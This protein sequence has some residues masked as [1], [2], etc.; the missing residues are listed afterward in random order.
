MALRASKPIQARA[1]VGLLV[2]V[3]TNFSPSSAF[4]GSSVGMDA[5]PYRSTNACEDTN[6]RVNATFSR[7]GY[8]SRSEL[9][10]GVLALA[11]AE[12]VLGDS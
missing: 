6:P 2:F 11:I 8:V 9:N 5:A 10:G 1:V 7:S 12:F 3:G 4:A